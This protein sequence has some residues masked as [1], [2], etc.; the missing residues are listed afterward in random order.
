MD[1]LFVREAE[2]PALSLSL[3]KVPKR[4]V[5]FKCPTLQAAEK[6]PSLAF[7]D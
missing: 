1:L 2:T 7:S 6:A 5:L 4:S 3:R